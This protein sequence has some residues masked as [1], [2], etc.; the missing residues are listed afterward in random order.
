MMHEELL[1]SF[2]EVGVAFAGFAGLVSVVSQRAEPSG[3][4]TYDRIAMIGFSVQ[5]AV[6][7]FVPRVLA[8]L[9]VA[10]AI[11]W[12]ASAALVALALAAWSLYGISNRRVLARADGLSGHA[13]FDY[14]TPVALASAVALAA[15]A[16]LGTLER[17]AGVYVSA[18]LGM[19]VSS[20]AYFVR[21]LIPRR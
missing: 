18:L 16:A 6:Y 19:L 15:C 14:L 9:G 2:A 12:R 10:D 20:G 7:S 11:V 13:A 4:A 17:V 1:G 21:M 5:A 3:L 8:A